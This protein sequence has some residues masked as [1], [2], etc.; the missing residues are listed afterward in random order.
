MFAC[1]LLVV[2]ISDCSDTLS[3]Y[4]VLALPA[5]EYPRI[6]IPYLISVHANW[7]I[8]QNNL[9]MKLMS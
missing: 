7:V 9:N 4:R 2:P 5:H 6:L 3:S 1:V 8:L